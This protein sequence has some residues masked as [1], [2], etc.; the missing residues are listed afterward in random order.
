MD[1]VLPTKGK[2]NDRQS[3]VDSSIDATG[4]I[5]SRWTEAGHDGIINV[6]PRSLRSLLNGLDPKD[7]QKAF[8]PTPVAP[9]LTDILLDAWSLT[10]ITT[11]MPGRPEVAP[12]LHGLTDDPPETYVAWRK[13]VG[14]LSAAKADP[15]ALHD[16]FLACP[17]KAHERL[18][19]RP[20]HVKKTL[21]SL[22]RNHRRKDEGRDFPL[23]LLNE[24]GE[25]EWSRL[26]QI[27]G[28]QFDLDYRTIVLPIEAGGL[29]QHGALD[30]KAVHEA[31]DVGEEN[32]LERR[33]RWIMITDEAGGRYER[34]M[35][36]ETEGTLPK[37]LRE[38]EQAVLQEAAEGAEERQES[39]Y[40]LIMVESKQL[41]VEHPETARFRQPLSLHSNRI[42]EHMGRIADALDL[43]PPLRQAA[44]AA[45]QWH[46]RGK[47]RPVWQRFACNPPPA[48][49]LAK[50][51]K[52]LHG[53][54][55]GGY[56][57][58]F[59]S[60]LEAV[61]DDEIKTHT[62]AD[63]ILHLIAAHHGWARPH[64]EWRAWDQ[65]RTTIDNERAAAEV[66]RRFAR[67]QRRFGRWGLAWLESL[68]RS[69]DIAASKQV[70]ER[71]DEAQPKEARA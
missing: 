3:E 34:L 37:G 21:E 2:E 38:R 4:G 45:A 61:A 48:E 54:E 59:G 8:A 33:E 43:E 70:A 44:I 19:D 29:D 40:L 60:L 14:L 25:A 35:T 71:A 51:T 39:R 23:V 46:D 5:L 28:K 65:T 31:R 36:G 50:S 13:E 62:E 11:Q 15:E 9:P 26:S 18:R 42:C 67:L 16:W 68:L 47:N 69:A 58:E 56:R 32:K 41:A 64:F 57:H 7:L 30:A 1:V 10:G 24:R 17:V 55:L 12:Y 27:I 22:L 63:L 52:Y 66:M 49:P 6:S 53:R 20:Y